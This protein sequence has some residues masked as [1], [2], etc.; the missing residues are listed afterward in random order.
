MS[1]R[2]KISDSLV[3]ENSRKN[4]LIIPARTVPYGLQYDYFVSAVWWDVVRISG[5]FDTNQSN[6]VKP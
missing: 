3:S 5:Q 6:S 2:Y 4:V 1:I